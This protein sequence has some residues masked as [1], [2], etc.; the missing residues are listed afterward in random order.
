MAAEVVNAVASSTVYADV[1]FFLSITAA[2]V[3]LATLTV[4]YTQMKIASAKVRLDLYS[5]RF[6]VYLSALRYHQAVWGKEEFETSES[7]FVKC[8][9]ESK[10]LFDHKDGIYDTLTKIK[11]CGGVIRTNNEIQEGNSI[12][13]KG[14]AI[15]FDDLCD[16]KRQEM[17]QELIKLEDQLAKYI[18]FKVVRG[19]TAF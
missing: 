4:G 1:T 17:T 2:L 9:R 13:N 11:N 8:Y 19:W 16:S 18:D 12:I 5:K 7:E 14:S 15:A 3:S 10:F 6:N